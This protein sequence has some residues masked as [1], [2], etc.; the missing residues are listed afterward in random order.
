M[1]VVAVTG[2]NGFVGRALLEWLSSRGMRTRA[3]VRSKD[4]RC[5]GLACDELVEIGDMA[6]IADWRPLVAGANAIIHL[7]ARVHRM[8]SS[9]EA[10]YERENVAVTER[11]AAAAVAEHVDHFVFVSS[12]KVNGEV[13]GKQPFTARDE[14]QPKDAYGRSKLQAE[15]RLKALRAPGMRLTIVRPPLVYGPGVGANFQ[16][17][18]K[19]VRSGIPLPF[20][21]IVNQRSLVSVWNL[22][23]SI[24]AAL[25]QDGPAEQTLLVADN[26]SPSTVE[27][28][29]GIARAM[30]RKANIVSVP[31]PLLRLLAR[32]TGR[33]A[34]LS[35]LT[36]SLRVDTSDTR[37][38]LK[39]NPPFTLAEAL[40]KTINADSQAAAK[41]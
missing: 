23:D 24:Y 26:E 4:E 14:P 22:A 12:I 20:G 6:Q 3:L 40:S 36:D 8:N 31:L 13:T 32:L 38:A 1:T 17:L 9:D 25:V 11:L 18:I 37:T 7:A 27:L 33:Q 21:S 29:R 30:N 35:R 19:L 28:M 10:A 34:D 41:R 15:L 39:W 16:R 5:A 2:A